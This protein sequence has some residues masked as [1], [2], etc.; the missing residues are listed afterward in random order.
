MH[1]KNNNKVGFEKSP[2]YSVNGGYS[3]MELFE[4]F[5]CYIENVK[6]KAGEI[7]GNG[8][9]IEA[10]NTQKNNGVT[11]H[12]VTVRTRGSATSPVFY[13]EDYFARK[14]SVEDVVADM[15]RIMENQPTLEGLNPD[16]L[17]EFEKM[18][19]YVRFRLI[20]YEDNRKLL[21]RIPYK[22][23]LDL[24]K[25]YYLEI[26]VKENQRGTIMINSK[27]MEIWGISLEELDRIA[28]I[29]MKQRKPAVIKTMGEI[30]RELFDVQLF[31]EETEKF[32]VATSK[33]MMYGASVLIYDNLFDKLSEKLNCDLFIIPSSVNELI[34]VPDN[35]VWNKEDIK[36][37]IFSINREEVAREE[38]LSDSLYYFNR[39]TGFVMMA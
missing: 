21:E 27:H 14:V 24:A 19:D 28:E 39:K 8:F 29:N 36:N 33:D 32:Y 35:G 30:I 9:E 31:K 18:R 5:D 15:V 26:G 13:M 16:E 34:I 12:G 1:A 10:V 38:R 20:N 7:F 25:V 17:V 2:P 3:V 4:D 6:M 11:K 37:C 23:V 22:D